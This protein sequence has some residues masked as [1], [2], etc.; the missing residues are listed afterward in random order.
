[1]SMPIDTQVDVIDD[2]V[3]AEVGGGSN[4]NQI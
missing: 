4:V 1:M 2:A 3:L